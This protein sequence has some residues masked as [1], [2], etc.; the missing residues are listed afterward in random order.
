MRHFLGKD[1]LALSVFVK[2]KS[3]CSHG[4]FR[5][6]KEAS[7][8]S[9]IPRSIIYRHYKTLIR[10]GLLRKDSL[11]FVLATRKEINKQYDTKH[12]ST[13]I[14]YTGES[15]TSIKH[16]LLLKLTEE[17]ARRQEYHYKALLNDSLSSRSY[18][19]R[20]IRAH[21]VEETKKRRL[22]KVKYSTLLNNVGFT[23]EY[24]GRIM[25]VS[26]TTSWNILKEA[27]EKGK[28]ST[29]VFSVKLKNMSYKQFLKEK[30]AI[31]ECYS[32][33]FWKNGVLSYNVCTLYSQKE[34]WNPPVKTPLLS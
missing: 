21:K 7:M 2:L 22:G 26:K 18:K 27:K 10:E 23:H 31:R 20:I 16:S 11:G 19:K 32:S 15:L 4:R 29:S 13:I 34:Y 24:N 14:H 12:C 1:V 28:C 3:S 17:A 33:A 6:L 8:R 9:G 30:D 5:N 25:G